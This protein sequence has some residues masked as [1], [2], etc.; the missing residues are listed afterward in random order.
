MRIFVKAK[1]RA[2]E[3][4]IEKIDES[5]FIV[6]VKEAPEKGKANQAIVK[7]TAEYFKTPASKI[8]I[9]RGSGSKNKII[10]LGY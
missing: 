2:K 10:D 6:F 7:V 5:H 1:P 9:I 8:K 4:K 3:N